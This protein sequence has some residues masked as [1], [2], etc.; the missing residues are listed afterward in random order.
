[1]SVLF[2]R[3]AR[4][5]R[6]QSHRLDRQVTLHVGGE[7]TELDRALAERIVEPLTRLVRHRL[8]HGIGAAEHRQAGKAAIAT[9]SLD[10]S[11]RADGIVIDLADDGTDADLGADLDGVQESIAGLGG[12]ID[13]QPVAGVGTRIR[14]RLPPGRVEGVLVAVGEETYVL[15]LGVIVESLPAET[16][17]IR[18]VSGLGQVIQLRG[19]FV[20]VIRLRRIFACA[21]AQ[22]DPRRALMIVV[23]ADDIR[24]ALY[25]DGVLGQHQGAVKPLAANF[26]PV[27]GIAG[28]TVLDDGRV[29]M[30]VD[31]AGVIAMARKPA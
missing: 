6:E 28:A 23:E 18:N 12:T 7:H 8:A 29:A 15:P 2:A 19:E 9:L 3:L 31:V 24:A 1:M 27:E 26:R 14:V 21:P 16:A 25:V 11:R 4:V 5:V 20:P 17:A 10:A 13:V 30:I 22:T